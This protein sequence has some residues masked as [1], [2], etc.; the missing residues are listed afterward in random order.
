MSVRFKTD[1]QNTAKKNGPWTLG[2]DLGVGTAI[3]IGRDNHICRYLCAAELIIKYKPNK[4]T[5]GIRVR[6]RCRDNHICKC[7]YATHATEI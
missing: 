2:L 7:L 4:Q 1:N 5:M 6:F 3:T